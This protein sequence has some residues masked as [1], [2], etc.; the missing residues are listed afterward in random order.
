MSYVHC[1][2]L[3]GVLVER[4]F[5]AKVCKD[6]PAMRRGQYLEKFVLK[7]IEKEKRIKL[8][9]CGLIIDHNNPIVGASADGINKEYVVEIKCPTMDKTIK[10]YVSNNKIVERYYAQLQLQ[11]YLHKR[12]KGIFCVASPQFEK[13]QNKSIQIIEV[14]LDKEYCKCLIKKIKRILGKSS[15]S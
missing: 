15:F 14:D 12:E 10:N 8:D 9:T 3:D 13:K 2:T 4:I 6:T 1:K 11:M 7:E 5:G